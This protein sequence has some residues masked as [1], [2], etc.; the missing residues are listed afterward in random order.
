MHCGVDRASVVKGDRTA[1]VVLCGANVLSEEQQFL[2]VYPL[3]LLQLCAIY[4]Q[5]FYLTS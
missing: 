1:A 5:D 3:S 2:D 4:M